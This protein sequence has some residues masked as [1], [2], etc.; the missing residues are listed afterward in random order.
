MLAETLRS[1]ALKA[2]GL[3]PQKLLVMS[4]QTRCRDDGFWCSNLELKH[5]SWIRKNHDMM[6]LHH[7]V[8]K[9]LHPPCIGLPTLYLLN[10]GKVC[11][12]CSLKDILQNSERRVKRWP[13]AELFLIP[14]W[15]DCHYK[16][17]SNIKGSHRTNLK[18]LG[19]WGYSGIPTT[20]HLRVPP[21]FERRYC[22]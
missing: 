15:V 20:Y 22:K 19:H 7:L 18:K 6:V 13:Q 21:R 17:M 14:T 8:I 12:L 5:E 4:S 9:W 16:G 11:H 3:G 1:E 10:V 2:I